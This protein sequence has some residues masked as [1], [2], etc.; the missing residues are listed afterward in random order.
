MLTQSSPGAEREAQPVTQQGQ[1]W[2]E[3]HPMGSHCCAH[4]ELLLAP[5]I[6]QTKT[7]VG[8]ACLDHL[9]SRAFSHP[10]I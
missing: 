8:N 7:A 2:V 6:P 3:G 9:R 10:F 4:S 5:Q 1:L